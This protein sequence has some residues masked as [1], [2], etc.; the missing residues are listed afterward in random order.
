MELANGLELMVRPFL[1]VGWSGLTDR[2]FPSYIVEFRERVGD[3]GKIVE[4]A[5]QEAVLGHPSTTCF[6]THCGWSSH[7]ES[8]SNGVPLPDESRIVLRYDIKKKVEELLSGK[9]I[10]D[11]ALRLKGMAR[12]SISKGGSSLVNLE[13]VVSQMKS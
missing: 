2:S 13:H 10:R 7:M 12:S 3:R 1:W 4:W 5:L 8:L 6:I 11:N 9:I